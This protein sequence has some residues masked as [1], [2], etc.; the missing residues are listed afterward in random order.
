MISMR[1]AYEKIGANYDDACARLMGEEMLAPLPSSFWMTRAWTS[2]RPP[3]RQET[4]KGAFMAAH[5]LKGV[6]QNLGFD[7][8]YEPAVVVTEALRG[9][10]AVDGAREECMRMR[11]GIISLVVLC[12]IDHNISRGVSPFTKTHMRLIRVLALAFAVNAAVSL[13]WCLWM[14]SISPLA[15]WSFT[16]CLIPSLL[17]FAKALPL[18]RVAYRRGCLSVYLGDLGYASLLQEQSD[19]LV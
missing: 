5:T 17:R 16:S 4:P 10:D 11:V 19:E 2:W 13:C 12:G 14:R 15:D 8:L 9:A 7:N 1:E 18:M 3:W 6:S